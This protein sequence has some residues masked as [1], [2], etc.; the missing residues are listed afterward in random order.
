MKVLNLRGINDLRLEEKEKPVPK[1]GEVLVEI[2]ACGICSSDEARVLKTGTYHF[3]TVPGHEFSG[4]VVEVGDFVDKKYLNKKVAVFPLLPCFECT[5]CKKGE[6]ALCSNYKY[7]GSRNDGGFAEYLAV[8]VWNLVELDDSIDYKVGALMEPSAVALH[9]VN[10]GNVKEGDNV[11]VV[12]TGTIGI[13][14]GAFCKLKGANVWL[15]GHSQNK[16][17]NVK[18]LDLDVLDLKDPVNDALNIT[19]FERMDVV[20]EAVGSEDS[21]KNC[22]LLAKNSG[23]I[24]TVGNPRGDFKLEKDVYW[25]ILRR[26]L[27]IKGTWNSEYNDSNNDWKEVAKLMKEKNFPFEKLITSLFKLE[28]YDEAFDI[29]SD[30][31]KFKTKIMF[32]INKEE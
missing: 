26:Q 18:A 30:K 21:L 29:L 12:G 24:V 25:K 14:I 8:P 2:H 19:N 9:A 15:S 22:I 31:N 16:I 4:K 6:Y 3:P 17:D 5:A 23:T 1:A 10:I 20:F 32:E 13:L 28:E 27:T 7:F 11:V